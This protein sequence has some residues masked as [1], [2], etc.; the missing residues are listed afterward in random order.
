MCGIAGVVAL[1]GR[2]YSAQID[3][4]NADVERRGPDDSGCFRKENVFLGHRRL[5]VIDTSSDGHQPMTRGRLTLTYNGEIYNYL[6]L[7]EALRKLGHT[8]STKSDSEV[9]LASYAEWGPSCVDHFD[10]MWAFALFDEE[11]RELFCSRDRFG[12]KPFYWHADEFGFAFGS[13]LRQLHRFRRNR[14]ANPAVLAEYLVRGIEDSGAETIFEGLYR[15]EPGTNVTVSTTTGA[16]HFARYYEPGQSSD[17]SNIDAD[18]VLPTL[19]RELD[20]AL[21]QMLRSDVPVGTALSGGID[22]SLI[23]SRIALISGESAQYSAISVSSGDVRN[24]ESVSAEAVARNS[25]IPWRAVS[26]GRDRVAAAMATVFAVH[27]VP[28]GGPS[29]AMQ[30]LLME[31]ASAAGITVL[32][33]GQGAD[34]CWL[35]YPRYWAAA[36]AESRKRDR[37]KLA[38]QASQMSGLGAVRLS[39]M[40]GYFANPQVANWRNDR[41]WRFLKG[42]L[43]GTL[44]DDSVTDRHAPRSV[45]QMQVQELNKY[46]VPHLMRLEDCNSMHFSIESRLPFLDRRLVEL[47]LATPTFEKLRGGWSKFPLRQL[48]AAS[49]SPEIAWRRKKIGFEAPSF[50]WRPEGSSRVVTQSPF[51]QSLLKPNSNINLSDPMVKWR[52]Y[53]LA[54]WADCHS[55]QELGC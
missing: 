41:R 47:S 2:D 16:L 40:L 17:F 55:V 25:G 11:K 23:A 6:E 39:M 19:T 26:A 52:L 3:A 51:V 30:F 20:R 31:E 8:F 12:E 37:P 44:T 54:R 13:A 32:L 45:K 28:I 7:R 34:E 4:M 24:D 22:S 29:I 14:A 10:G 15:L 35:G 33:D 50:A 49:E 21:S 43:L 48:L 1:D 18:Q 5:A 42:S 9:L 53:S 46:G 36:I 27:D 38:W